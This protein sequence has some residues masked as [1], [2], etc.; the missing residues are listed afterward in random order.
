[1]KRISK[2]INFI[3]EGFSQPSKIDRNLYNYVLY[4]TFEGEAYWENR[5]IYLIYLSIKD[6]DGKQKGENETYFTKDRYKPYF[7]DIIQNNNTSNW[8]DDSLDFLLS[9]RLG[10]PVDLVD[11]ILLTEDSEDINS[12]DDLFGVIGYD[13]LHKINVDYIGITHLVN[14]PGGFNIVKE[15]MF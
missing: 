6:K 1:M 2:F 14:H 3:K 13:L 7:Y 10:I 9:T 11:G 15:K 4:L 8:T 12:L 5:N